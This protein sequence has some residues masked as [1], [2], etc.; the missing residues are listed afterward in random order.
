MVDSFKRGRE[1]LP[2]LNKRVIKKP[3]TH[4]NR[5]VFDQLRIM[6]EG[7]AQI[8]CKSLKRSFIATAHELS[9]LFFFKAIRP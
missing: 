3:F 2:G 9:L 4:V 8:K 7:I 1:G 6:T 5:R